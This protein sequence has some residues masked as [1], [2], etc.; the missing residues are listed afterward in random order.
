[1]NKTWV[2]LGVAGALL[3]MVAIYGQQ[4][5]GRWRTP[6][7]EL[8]TL[9]QQ[10]DELERN[11]QPDALEQAIQSETTLPGP[12]PTGAAAATDLNTLEKDLD[13]LQLE[14]ETFQ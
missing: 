1:M 6:Q 12:S 3:L 4:K 9:E 10:A 7:S 14:P 13:T 2:V 8:T 5:W 11:N